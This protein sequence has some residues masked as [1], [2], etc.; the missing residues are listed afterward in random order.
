MKKEI[1]R[2]LALAVALAVQWSCGGSSTPSRPTAVT[3]PAPTPQPPV[4]VLEGSFSL[5]AGFIGVSPTI[6]VPSSGV[7]TVTVDWTFATNDLDIA[8]VRGTCT[9]AMFDAET[10][11]VIAFTESA[12][13]KPETLTVNV[14]AG[15]YTPLVGNFGTGDES[16]ALQAVFTAGATASSTAAIRAWKPKAPARFLQQAR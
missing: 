7:L 8:L 13:A 4:V 15:S 12:T 16:G 3:T 9:E 11:D 10:C 14:T 6:S 2:A 1:R 5:P